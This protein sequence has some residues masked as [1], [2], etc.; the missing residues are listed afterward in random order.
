MVSSQPS[1]GAAAPRYLSLR[2]RRALAVSI[3]LHALLILALIRA[4][5]QDEPSRTPAPA[6]IV[7]LG[8]L[9]T[10][11]PPPPPAPPRAA[12]VPP[13]VE[14]PPAP[15][16]TVPAPAQT[17]PA[18]TPARAK[19]P[20]R[21]RAEA[22]SA[23]PASPRAPPELPARPRAPP[24]PAVEG[25]QVDFEALRRRAV[26]QVVEQQARARNYHTFSLDDAVGKAAPA[27]P[28]PWQGVWKA[29]FEGRLGGPSDEPSLM[30]AG[31]QRTKVGRAVAGLCQALL[32]GGNFFGLFSLCGS[33]DSG[34][35]LDSP[36]RPDYLK[37][38]PLCAQATQE[39]LAA[40]LA[41]GADSIPS[42]K[43]RLVDD[44]ERQ[45]IL[46]RAGEHGPT[47][48]H[49]RA[50]EDEPAGGAAAR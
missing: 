47:G 20:Q 21:P 9:R 26:A 42:L 35:D 5:R 13:P 25:G 10:A 14:T 28:N 49:V 27:D 30:H 19:P 39:Q 4:E 12:P 15:A 11:P 24:S 33:Y 48:E 45:A 3:F 37:K 8:E 32:G 50:G 44:A 23:R 6:T 46:K 43:C 41:S 36:I 29:A 2:G 38:R 31:Q 22:S 18:P 40:A 1:A 7:W 16:E 34:P 17:A